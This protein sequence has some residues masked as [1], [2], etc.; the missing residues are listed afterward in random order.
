MTKNIEITKKFQMRNGTDVVVKGILYLEKELWLDGDRDVV[1]TCEIS[2]NVEVAGHGNQ[3]GWVRKLNAN[4]LKQAPAG[5][6]HVCG[7]LGLTTEQAE[8]I[9]SV[10]AELEQQPEWVE[11]MN[12]VA[13]AEKET[14]EYYEHVR[15]VNKMMDM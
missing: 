13:Q 3:G 6:T 7:N 11:H 9:K 5:Y 8:L 2:V 4:E 12:R 15:R 10:R 14:D 1:P